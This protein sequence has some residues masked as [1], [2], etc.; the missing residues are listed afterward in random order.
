MRL[1]EVQQP[2]DRSELAKILEP[3]LTF[4]GFVVGP[5]SKKST[6]MINKV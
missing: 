5:S 2:Q 3:F 1:Y 6:A 4:L